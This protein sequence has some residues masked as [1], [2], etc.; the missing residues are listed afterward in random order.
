[1]QY[2]PSKLPSS[3]TEYSVKF[4][5]LKGGLNISDLD[6][7]LKANESPYMEN[8]MWMDGTL[9]SRDGQFYL[10]NTNLVKAH[11][12]YSRLYHGCWFAHINTRLYVFRES[13]GTVSY[14]ALYAGLAQVR[15]TFFMYDGNLYYKT[16]GAYLKI[17]ATL[18]GDTWVFYVSNV[19][20]YTPVVLINA[21]PHTAAGDLYQPENR[22]S[23]YKTVWY[24]AVSGVH[25][26]HLPVKATSVSKIVVDG[27]ETT[28]YSYNSNTGIVTF[29]NCPPVTNPPTNNT[30]QITYMLANTD[31][32]KSI[33]DCR[34]V[35]VYGGTGNLCILMA[36][37]EAQP[38][39]FFWNGN[40]NVSMDPGYF[41]MEQ[42]QLAGDGLDAVTGFG[43]QQSY[44]VIFKEGSVGRSVMNTEEVDGRIY[45]DFPYT[46]INAKI[47]CDLPWTIQLIEN[48]L[49]W[50]HSRT[51]IHMLRDSTAAM[52]INIV[53]L[54][55]KISS[56]GNALSIT[57][58]L[59]TANKDAVCSCD[60]DK[61]YWVCAG[62]KC[63]LWNYEISTYNEPSWFYYSGINA[64]TFIHDS[65]KTWHLDTSGRLVEFARIFND[66]GSAITKEYR[67]PAQKFGSYDRL[68][69][70]NS[71]IFAMRNDA[72][73][74]ATISYSAESD[75]RTDLTPLDGSQRA[76]PN[77]YA[78]VFRRKPGC[79]RV[80]H[81]AMQLSNSVLLKDLSII[82]AEILFNYQG[83]LR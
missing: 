17:S 45:I 14:S 23:A 25:D 49:V 9:S 10:S 52:E 11:A 22:M 31:A 70:I 83:R 16:K 80:R 65:T 60:D 20:A 30:V 5:N 15:G 56:K 7:H 67:F 38:N 71:V 29:Y 24:N 51:G 26:Y 32:Q 37:S 64:A 53:G 13:A 63:W 81:F 66:F 78:L 73:N 43:K 82:S 4:E 28:S 54:S 44:L 72:D 59:E 12:A 6:Y 34:F 19:Q 68:K 69:N 50:C 27:V 47:G 48:N 75:I 39:A 18:S 1:M 42:Y 55:K 58:T 74:Y 77:D 8:L 35:E 46:P 76:S 21:D 79:K 36:G 40:T 33:S 61:C 3:K 41:P 57:D 2:K 62:G